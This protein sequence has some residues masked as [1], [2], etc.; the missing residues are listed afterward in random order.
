MESKLFS[1]K[2]KFGTILFK[3]DSSIPKQIEFLENSSDPNAGRKIKLLEIEKRGEEDVLF[4]LIKS[5]SGIDMFIL[6]DLCLSCSN[7]VGAQIDF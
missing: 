6:R 7:D 4:E 1:S 3:E 2:K 5:N